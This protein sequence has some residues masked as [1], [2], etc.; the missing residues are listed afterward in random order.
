MIS[1]IGQSVCSWS[2]ILLQRNIGF[3]LLKIMKHFKQQVQSLIEIH[4]S[5]NNHV[6]FKVIALNTISVECQYLDMSTQY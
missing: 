3:V 5:S 4:A 1:L 2:L 6:N